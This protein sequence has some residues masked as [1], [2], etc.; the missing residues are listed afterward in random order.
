MNHR[1]MK[2]GQSVLSW[3]AQ[4]KGGVIGFFALAAVVFIA[5]LG[6]VQSV[7]AFNS[8]LSAAHDQYPFIPNSR[9]DTCLLC[10]VSGSFARNP[11]GQAYKASGRNF[12]TIEILDSDG[13]GFS[14]L[15]ELMAL[16]FPGNP[17]DVPVQPTPTFTPF[18]PATDTPTP[19]VEPP[20]ATP[21][22]A[23]PPTDTPV[24]TDI[25][26]PTVTPIPTETTP[27]PPY[28]GP[29]E[30]PPTTTATPTDVAPGTPTE[31]PTQEPTTTPPGTPE[32]TPMPE[33]GV[34]DLDVR[35]FKVRKE[36]KMEKVRPID[37]R[38][39]V[40]NNGL[41]EGQGTATVI[42]IQNG[43]EVYNQSL[44]VSDAVGKGHRRY[45]F[46]SYLPTASG[47]I[48][49]TLSLSDDDP[50]I[51]EA[52]EVTT[53]IGQGD[54]GGGEPGALDLDIHN[55]KVTSKIKLDKVKAIEIRVDVKNNGLSSGQGSLIVTGVQN[56][57]EVYNQSWKVSDLAGGGQ[58][59]YFLA[60]YVP[61]TAGEILWTITIS[62]DD[63][64]D[65]TAVA[66]TLV[67]P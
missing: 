57:V 3:I 55:F 10:H 40:K 35:D 50:D 60:S 26:P 42:G 9:L 59:R 58:S 56:G 33:V 38:L 5:L 34:F 19:T 11:Y 29:T 67:E 32:V 17:D 25:T 30:T 45:Y 54:P 66:A 15:E 62:D 47:E 22:D 36:I 43:V 13:D 53:V 37:I 18:P 64:D 27:P 1:K 48:V 16:S 63:P 7:Q 21:T 39:D 2:Q 14:N 61:S 20:T 4:F 31:T 65:D 41:A 52:V 6:V 28:P 49:W 8:D 51:D 46:P 24:P 23:P 12:V 44:P